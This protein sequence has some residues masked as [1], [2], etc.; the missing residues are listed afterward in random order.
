MVPGSLR[1]FYEEMVFGPLAGQ[2]STT[3][4]VFGYFAENGNGNFMFGRGGIVG[5]I[6][7]TM[8]DG[9]KIRPDAIK[10]AADQGDVQFSKF[11]RNHD[12]TVTSDE[13]SM[14]VMYSK[15]GAQSG[16]HAVNVQG[17]RI[18]IGV[19]AVGPGSE[20]G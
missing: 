18:R 20:L 4:S 7:Y 2:P 5:P 19:S 8:T 11:D 3:R 14:L 1:S 17:L 16:V 13:L 6:P 15:P 9:N 12:G 10:L